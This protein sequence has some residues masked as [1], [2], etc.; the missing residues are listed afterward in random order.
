MSQSEARLY[1]A[2]AAS[3][4]QDVFV[5]VMIRVDQPVKDMREIFSGNSQFAGSSR[6]SEGQYHSMGV[7]YTSGCRDLEN[8]VV[9]LHSLYALSGTNIQIVAP[10]NLF[11]DIQQ[12]L[13]A[14]SRLLQFAVKWK[15]DWTGHDQFLARVFGDRPSDSFPLQG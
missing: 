10:H 9:P 1:R 3:Y 8:S 15:F 5:R 14:Q 7:V 4:H 2:V 12:L 6:S 13:F 11:P